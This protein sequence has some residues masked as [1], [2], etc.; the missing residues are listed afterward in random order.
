MAAEKIGGVD[1]SWNATRPKSVLRHALIRL[2]L[3]TTRRAGEDEQLEARIEQYAA[4]LVVY[5]MDIALPALDRWPEQSQWWPSW[6]ELTQ[7]MNVAINERRLSLPK[8]RGLPE[9][10]PLPRGNVREFEPFKTR[11]EWD[12]FAGAMRDLRDKAKPMLCREALLKM[13][14]NIESRQRP[15]AERQ[16]WA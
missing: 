9:H 13:G 4:D 3:R 7:A 11:G 16:G 12:E 2:S 15:H 10:K 14:E 6:H 1:G 8:P 5:P